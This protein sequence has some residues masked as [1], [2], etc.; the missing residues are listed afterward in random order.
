MN[1]CHECGAKILLY[2]DKALTGQELEEFRRHLD[3]CSN[4]RE[5]VEAEKALSHVLYRVRPLYSAPD[6]LRRR[7]AATNAHLAANAGFDP[8]YQRV[9]R[10]FRRLPP[11]KPNRLSRFMAPAFAACAIAFCLAIVPN[12]VRQVRAANYVETAVAQHRRYLS[13]TL[14]AGLRSSS[15][16]LV[17]AWF[18]GKVPFNFRLPAGQA[19][20]ENKPTYQLTGARLVNCNG[21]HA[22]LVTYESSSDKISLFVASSSTAVVAG[23]DEVRFRT[24]TFHYHTNSGFKVITWSNHG[25]SYALVYSASAAAR[26][27]CLVC[28]QNMADSKSFQ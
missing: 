20:P 25:L 15:P 16:E 23:G 22:A 21:N 27:S 13:G 14:D 24:L 5:Y 6:A 12:V 3:S 26:T 4:C 10:A 1:S 9:F 18:A 2:L 8:V 7:V 17:T 19:F 11:R 28:H